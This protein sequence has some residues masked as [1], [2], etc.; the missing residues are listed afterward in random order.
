MIQKRR[1]HELEES[2]LELSFDESDQG[3]TVALP[4]LG[5]HPDDWKKENPF[6]KHRYFGGKQL[7]TPEHE[8]SLR[9]ERAEKRRKKS[10]KIQNGTRDLVV[11]IMHPASLA[12]R[13]NEVMAEMRTV[14]ELSTSSKLRDL[15]PRLNAI[16]TTLASLGVLEPL[17]SS[18]GP[19][20][21]NVPMFH[22]RS[23]TT[24]GEA[25][26]G[27]FHYYLDEILPT[28]VSGEA[29]DGEAAL[30]IYRQNIHRTTMEARRLM[31]ELQKK[32]AK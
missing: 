9:E 30:E 1:N 32:K 6:H 18:P 21:W 11:D 25:F 23:G 2:Q 4:A 14:E 27:S 29:Q 12:D 31:Q 3:N 19:A 17:Y 26:L 22:Q 5:D 15:Y 24:M 8:Q 13:A 28:L 10:E 16:R 20:N 7:R